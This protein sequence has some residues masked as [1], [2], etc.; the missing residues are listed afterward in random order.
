MPVCRAFGVGGAACSVG[1]MHNK[2]SSD[3]NAYDSIHCKFCLA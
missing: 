1:L 2:D 3:A